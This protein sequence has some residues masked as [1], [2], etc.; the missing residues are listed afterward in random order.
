MRRGSDPSPLVAI[1]IGIGMFLVLA[2]IVMSALH[3]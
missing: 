2:W 3:H 1:F